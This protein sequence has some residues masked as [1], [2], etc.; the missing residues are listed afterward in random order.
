[1]E[2]QNNPSQT[3]LKFYLLPDSDAFSL[4][5]QSRV[6]HSK[7]TKRGYLYKDSYGAQHAGWKVPKMHT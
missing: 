2:Q 7:L 6:R 5:L 4:V 1:M 3:V